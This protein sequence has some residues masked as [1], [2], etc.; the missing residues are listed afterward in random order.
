MGFEPLLELG[1]HREVVVAEALAEGGFEALTVFLGAA[2]VL[3]AVGADEMQLRVEAVE[4]ERLPFARVEPHASGEGAP[5]DREVESLADL[6]PGEQPAGLGTEQG[7]PFAIVR[8]PNLRCRW[9]LRCGIRGSAGCWRIGPIKLRFT[10]NPLNIGQSGCISL[11]RWP[12][13][14]SMD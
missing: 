4:F 9:G 7:L 12:C 1:H 11:A 10:E 13:W 2:F 6:E 5:F 14:R 3:V 8:R